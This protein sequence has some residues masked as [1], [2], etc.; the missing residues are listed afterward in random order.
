MPM[1]QVRMNAIASILD[2]SDSYEDQAA[3]SDN[4][5]SRK[6]YQKDASDLRDIAEALKMYQDDKAKVKT[7]NLDT[8]VRD[9]IPFE[10]WVFVG[11]RPI[12]NR[13]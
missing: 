9:E 1:D 12:H 10:A 3:G 5:S 4:I 6:M 8:A 11:L 2:V 7:A 13:R